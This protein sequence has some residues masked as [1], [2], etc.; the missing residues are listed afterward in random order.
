MGKLA[1]E[2]WPHLHL[3]IGNSVSASPEQAHISF[4]HFDFIPEGSSSVG[5]IPMSW[6]GA[7]SSL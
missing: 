6:I 4:H 5:V 3:A 1:H 7:L 2:E